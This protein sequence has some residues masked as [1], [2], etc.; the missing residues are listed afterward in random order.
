MLKLLAFKQLCPLLK[1]QPES[2]T[3]QKKLDKS[4]HHQKKI[5]DPLLPQNTKDDEKKIFKIQKHRIKKKA[6][7]KKSTK[8]DHEKKINKTPTKTKKL[9]ARGGSPQPHSSI[10]RAEK[11]SNLND[12]HNSL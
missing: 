2:R 4:H 6:S 9:A 11:I 12:V 10:N 7:K 8:F 5:Q 3:L 1:P